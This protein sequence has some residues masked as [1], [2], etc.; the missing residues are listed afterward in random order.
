M[1]ASFLV[2]SAGNNFFYL[3]T[4][5]WDLSL[6]VSCF[7]CKQSKARFP[8]MVIGAHSYPKIQKHL[9]YVPFSQC[10]YHLRATAANLGLLYTVRMKSNL[11]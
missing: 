7:F 11:V 6:V 10:V 1:H 5:S 3:F 8:G 2:P 9:G 4:L